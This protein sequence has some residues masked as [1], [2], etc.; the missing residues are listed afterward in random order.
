MAVASTR[1]AR[2]TQGD[3]AREANVSQSAV[4]AVLR[5][6]ASVAIAPDTRQ[7][8]LDAADRLVYVPNTSAQGLRS[9]RTMTVACVIPDITN[10][11]YPAFER[12]AQT[13]AN[14]FAYDFA[15][16]N[17][18][19]V[20]AG[21]LRC[22]HLLRGGRVDGIIVAPFQVETDDL[23]PLVELGLPVVSFGQ[24]EREPDVLPFDSV[25]VNDVAGVAAMV[26]HLVSQG[27]IR[28]GMIAGVPNISRRDGRVL[29]FHEALAR[30][31]IEGAGSFIRG[32]D[33][34]EVGGYQAMQRLLADGNRPS[35]VFATNDLM[36]IGAISAARDAGLEIPRDIAVAGFDDIPFARLLYPS[37]TTVAQ[38]PE[39][40]GRRAAELLFDR[41]AGGF[42]GPGRRVEMP[43]RLVI[44]SSA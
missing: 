26:D 36:A 41:V 7:R 19:G 42:K 24:L 28:I 15:V 18:D 21:E 43:F 22:L 29:G 39:D 16:Y 27:H 5:G 38:F 3:V 17:T 11:F 2:P 34:T 13:V 20:R 6:D 1:R 44:R 4:S 37:L 10:P 31:G 30:H 33:Y 12:G 25:L 40:L 9:N 32:D 23:T 14:G 35:A 8:I